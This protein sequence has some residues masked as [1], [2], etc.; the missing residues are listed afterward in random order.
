MYPAAH[1]LSIA[2]VDQGTTGEGSKNLPQHPRLHFGNSWRIQPGR[3]M[4]NHTRS[5][6]SVGCWLECPI[7]NTAVKMDML[8]ERRT[9]TVDEGDRAYAGLDVATGAVFAQT[10]F[11]LAQKDAQYGTLQGDITLEKL[12]ATK[13]P[14]YFIKSE[15]GIR[16]GIVCHIKK[17][18]M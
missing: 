8:V 2:L 13:A 9:E 7:D 12:Y 6:V 1:H 3:R 18:K 4:K 15:G 16:R 17:R 5:F 14:T 11:H 10:P